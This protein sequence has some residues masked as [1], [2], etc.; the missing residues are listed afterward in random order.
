MFS[1]AKIKAWLVIAGGVAFLIL[2]LLQRIFVLGSNDAKAKNTIA[3]EKAREKS[4]ERIKKARTAGE[5]VRTDAD[6]GVLDIRAD[7]G[8]KRKRKGDSDGA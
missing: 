1:W 2:L 5:S 7:D 3:L 4:A 8:H 6:R